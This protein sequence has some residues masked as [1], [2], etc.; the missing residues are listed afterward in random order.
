VT[1]PVL[2]QVD[3]DRARTEIFQSWQ[4]VNAE[5]TPAVPIFCYP[6][7]TPA[8]FSHRDESIVS[9]AGM[10]A[11]FSTVQ[12]SIRSG[13]SGLKVKDPFAIPR[14]SYPDSDASFVEICS[15]LHALRHPW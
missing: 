7:G 15:G 3:P 14:Y 13:R 11:A 12:A 2:S 4:T 10:K 1:H 9:G 6:N 8:D 5:V